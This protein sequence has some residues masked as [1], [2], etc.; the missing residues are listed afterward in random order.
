M[1]RTIVILPPLEH[2]PG[3][4]VSH[5]EY[6]K[7][8]R[9][10]TWLRESL[11]EIDR[12]ELAIISSRTRCAQA[13]ARFIG[14]ALDCADLEEEECLDSAMPHGTVA[15]D[16]S[17]IRHLAA[18]KLAIKSQLILVTHAGHYITGSFLKNALEAEVV[19]QHTFCGADVIKF[20]EKSSQA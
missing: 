12:A 16:V 9:L 18:E 1:L 20:E 6:E 7:A 11:G 10:I 5:D 2:Q 15:Q 17:K 3:E 8:G 14:G 13:M 19:Y 4:L